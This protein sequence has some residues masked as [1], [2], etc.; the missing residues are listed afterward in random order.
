M[1]RP[2]L[3][4]LVWV[5]ERGRIELYV[6]APPTVRSALL[7]STGALVQVSNLKLP[8]RSKGVGHGVIYRTPILLRKKGDKIV[9]GPV[10]AILAGSGNHSFIGSRLNFRDIMQ[11]ARQQGKFVYVIPP[12][13]VTEAGVWQGYVRLGYQRWVKLPC[14]RPE[15]VYNRIPT[16]LHERQ[17]AVTTA[18]ERLKRAGIPMFNV[19]YF[20]KAVIYDVI[21]SSHIERYLPETSNRFNALELSR[22]LRRNGSVYLKP[23]GGSIGHGMMLIRHAGVRYV[24]RVLKNNTGSNYSAAS[25]QEVWELIE[26]HRVKGQYV[27]QAAKSVIEW[28]GRPCDF[29]VLLQKLRGRWRMVGK[30]VRV[31]GAGSITTHV[32][33]GGSIANAREVLEQA[34]GDE[35]TN[36]SQNLERMTIQCAEVIDHHFNESLGEMS[37]DIGIDTSGELWFFEANAKPMKFDEPDIRKKSLLGVIAHLEELRKSTS[38]S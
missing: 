4:E 6:D 14:P 34:F 19:S 23:T 8:W 18:K 28:H 17:A 16:R 31:A 20:N 37:M 7:D 29:R 21:R 27:I 5:R 33:N 36:V 10:F 11:Q 38:V 12:E 22:M 9:S 2:W 1:A 15:A 35:A 25:L 24:V 30:G 13:N 26:R 32:P 3:G